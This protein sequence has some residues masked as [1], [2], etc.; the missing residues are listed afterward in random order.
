VEEAL[1]W[2]PNEAES[3]T[4]GET[5]SV[6][7]M[8]AALPSFPSTLPSIPQA[9]ILLADD[10]SDMREYVGRL[11]ATNYEVEAVADGEAALQAARERP[12][13]GP[14][15]FGRDDAEPRWVR[16]VEGFARRRAL[17]DDFGHST[18]G[19]RRGGGARR[20]DGSWRRRLSDQAVQR[21]R[22]AGARQGA[23]G[24]DPPPARGGNGA[25][26]YREAFPRAGGQRSAHLL[27]DRRSGQH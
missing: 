22:T 26:P 20:G 2:L 8:D 15:S 10:N 1:R 4:D 25:A 24:D 7:A 27:D 12:P 19:A 11:L 18:F 9:R 17:G 6:D 5:R 14:R 13:D 16:L 3:Q 23:S 21:P